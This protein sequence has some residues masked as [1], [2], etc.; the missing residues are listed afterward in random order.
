MDSKEAEGDVVKEVEQADKEMV[1]G[2]KKE[3]GEN[4]EAARRLLTEDREEDK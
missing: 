1:K 4:R 3:H 2:N